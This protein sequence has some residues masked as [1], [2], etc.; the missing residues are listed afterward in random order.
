MNSFFVRFLILFAAVFG[1]IFLLVWF[2]LSVTSPAEA[3]EVEGGQ[4]LEVAF[5]RGE[6]HIIAQ[7]GREHVFT[8]ELALTP[9][10]QSRGLMFRETL[11]PDAGMLFVYDPPRAIAMW[12]RNTLV[13]LDMVF[14]GAGGTIFFIAE[15]T[16][17]LSEALI[18]PPA[19][20]GYVLEVPAG[21]ARRL[22]LVPGDRLRLSAAG[23]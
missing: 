2:Y 14:A 20:V 9:E 5:T 7:D 18:Q 15:N 21:T 22:G 4:A 1:L 12:M 19:G 6:A 16:E 13:P 11:A 23:K 8:V 3:G 10:Q 17:P